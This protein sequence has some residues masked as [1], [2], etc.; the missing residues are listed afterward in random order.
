MAKEHLLSPMFVTAETLHLLDGGGVGQAI[1]IALN[2]VIRDVE[3][4]G[5]DEEKR[6]VTIIL[7]FKKDMD[8]KAEPVDIACDVKVS[9]PALR[10]GNTVSKVYFKGA[11]AKLRFSPDA[12]DNPDQRTIVDDDGEVRE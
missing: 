3:D 1:D 5:K 7:T 12:S 8:N 10:A 11:E 9:L 2:Q 6:K 4:R